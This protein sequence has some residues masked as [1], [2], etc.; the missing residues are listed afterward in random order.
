MA[1]KYGWKTAHFSNTLRVVRRKT[2]YA[3]IPDREA[4]GFPD[5][6]LVRE[7]RIIFVELKGK[8]GRITEAQHD[9]LRALD[10]AGAETYIWREH[11]DWP[12]NV[13]KVLKK[14]PAR[15]GRAAKV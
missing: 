14:V 6:I 7:D 3:T 11:L 10:Q 5:L 13:A 12:G 4:I 9:W 8:T 15:T 2:G 1:Q